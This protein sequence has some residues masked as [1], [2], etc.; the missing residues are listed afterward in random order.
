MNLVLVGV[1]GAGKSE[2]GRRLARRLEIDF[3]DLDTLGTSELGDDLW[4][5]H[6]MLSTDADGQA[7]W[8]GLAS[9]NVHAILPQGDRVWFGRCETRARDVLGTGG[10]LRSSGRRQNL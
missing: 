3:V 10:L 7:P 2:A 9:D 1:R 6:S 8:T 4:Q 5:R